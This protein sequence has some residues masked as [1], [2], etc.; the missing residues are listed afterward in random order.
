MLI[1]NQNGPY[2]FINVDCWVISTTIN[3]VPPQNKE[4][5]PPLGRIR[6]LCIY[7]SIERTVAR[8]VRDHKQ[9]QI[10]RVSDHDSAARAAVCLRRSM[11]PY[12]PSFAFNPA[13]FQFFFYQQ[14]MERARQTKSAVGGAYGALH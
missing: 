3:R 13:T 7:L 5:N 9:I 10:L 2:S 11:M 8:V 1:C 14:T 12:S 6:L 4:K